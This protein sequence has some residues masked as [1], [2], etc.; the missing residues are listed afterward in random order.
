MAS[1]GSSE[2][3]P[4]NGDEPKSSLFLSGSPGAIGG[5]EITLK[6]TF[7]IAVARAEFRCASG[8]QGRNHATPLT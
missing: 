1:T 6:L 4:K 7:G 3:L 2:A 8:L 5:H